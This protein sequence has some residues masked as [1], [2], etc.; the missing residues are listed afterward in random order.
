[1]PFE[2][3]KCVF[4]CNS[5]LCLYKLSEYTNKKCNPKVLDLKT[6]F[7]YADSNSDEKY[8]TN[9][10]FLEWPK[11]HH[12]WGQSKG[13][14]LSFNLSGGRLRNN[15]MAANLGKCYK[16]DGAGLFWEGA[17]RIKMDSD[18]TFRDGR[19][20]V[21]EKGRWCFSG[22]SCVQGHGNSTLEWNESVMA[23]CSQ[24]S[25]TSSLVFFTDWLQAA[26]TGWIPGVPCS[27]H[28]Y[29]PCVYLWASALHL[30]DF[31]HV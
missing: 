12:Q 26:W 8:W 5:L 29:D 15:I 31:W 28:F 18:H 20:A 30:L 6:W 23:L 25:K 17:G 16:D 4:R 24:V 9:V 3:W 2:H 19:L 14:G 27:Q 21:K 10:Y 13:A 11:E 22:G 1:M 7:F